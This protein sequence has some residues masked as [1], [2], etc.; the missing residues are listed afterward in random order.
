MGQFGLMFRRK[1]IDPTQPPPPGSLPAGIE[2]RGPYQ[3]RAW[4]RRKGQPSQRRTF[5]LPEQAEAWLAELNRQADIGEAVADRTEVHRTTLAEA[6]DLYEAAETD[7][8]RGAVQEHARIRQWKAD[9]L[10]A[11]FVGAIRVHEVQKWIDAQTEA[12]K[13]PTTIGNA[14]NVL[15]Q[16]YKWLGSRPGFEGLANPVRGVRR[17]KSRTARSAFFPAG[18]DIE[19]RLLEAC[20]SGGATAESA[21]RAIWLPLL[22]RLALETAMRQGELL[23]MEWQHV[24]ASHIHLPTSKNG[25]ARDVPLS[26]AAKAIVAEMREALPRRVDGLV[27]GVGKNAV[28]NSF[29]KS[30]ARARKQAAIDGSSFPE[31]TF[32]DLRH[33]ATTRLAPK[34]GNVL[35]LSAVTGHQSLQVL[36]RYY[37]PSPESLADK[38]G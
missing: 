11:R 35:E 12:G 4:F 16:C 38:L 15:S 9:D 2:W 19:R 28:I 23:A 10:G 26:K 34:L 13:A 7:R 3:Y 30:V 17:P 24:H 22:V 27:F 37:N 25:R 5:D 6:L 14:L 33:V 8:K 21:R 18:G 1:K 32:H 31:V 20:S 36:K 29:I